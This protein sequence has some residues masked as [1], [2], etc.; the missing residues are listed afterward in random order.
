VERRFAAV[1]AADMVG[2]SRHVEQA[3]EQAVSLLHDHM[4]LIGQCVETHR[5]RV[6][7]GAGDSLVAEFNSPVE[8]IRCGLDIQ[9]A[10]EAEN[11]NLP[12]SDRMR[13]RVGIHAGDVVV[14]GGLLQGEVVNIAARIQALAPPGGVLVSEDVYRHVRRVLKFEFED[15]GER[16]LKNIAIPVRLYEV[17]TKPAP[18]VHRYISRFGRIRRRHAAALALA[19]MIAAVLGWSYRGDVARVWRATFAPQSVDSAE[20]S[21]AVLPFKNISTATGDDYFSDGLTQDITN[22]LTRF[23]NL[24][25]IASNSAFTYKGKTVKVKDIGNDLGAE[26]ILDG[27]VQRNSDRVRV[28]AQLV[29]AVNGWQVWGERYDRNGQDIFEIQDEVIRAVVTRLNSEVASAE[30][31]KIVDRRTA[32]VTAYD[33]YLKGRHVF[34]EYTQEAVEAAKAEFSAAIK[35]DPKF[36]Q[37]YGWLGYVY[38]TEV[39]EGWATDAPSNLSL[40]LQLALRGVELAPDDYYTHW[41]LA[42]VYAG[43]K[44]MDLAMEEYNRAIS[45]NANDADL[46]AEMADMLSYRGEPQKAIKQIA[47]AKELNP[48]YPDWYDW[49]L[50]FAYFQARD[51]AQAVAALR[52]MPDPPNTAYLLLVACKAKLGETTPVDEIKRRLLSKDPEWT[53]DHLDQYPFVNKEDQKHYLDALRNIGIYED[54]GAK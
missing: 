12:A 48:K 53:P 9:G 8:A 38:L 34:Y 17:H 41:N 52:R 26:Y 43:R 21:I 14:D 20:P 16:R 46:L 31:S 3:E 24:K 25:V 11:A 32:N 5:G 4:L 30:V 13:F 22:E 39:Q 51:Y 40:A 1:L 18:W 23:K 37:A 10:I 44:E 45:L 6:F 19:V 29:D 33:R 35:L 54:R 47:R 36:A 7:G 15:E 42:S 28:T 2:Y 49:S 27:S 50:G